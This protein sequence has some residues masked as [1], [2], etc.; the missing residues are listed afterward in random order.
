LKERLV[1]TRKGFNF[2]DSVP[3]ENQEE[4]LLK[5]YYH[6]WRTTK[7]NLNT[8]FVALYKDFKDKHLA[9][10]DGGPLRLYLYFS[11]NANNKFGHSWHS[12]ETIADFFD[13]QTRT[14]NNWIKT[15]IDKGLIY[16]EK[17]GRISHTTYLIPYSNS[18]TSQ[19]PK[20][21]YSEDGQELLEDLIS[22]IEERSFIFGEVKKVFHLFQWR[23][24]SNKP[25]IDKNG[26][27]ALLVITQRDDGVLIG[28]LCR[29]NNSSG[30]AINQLKIDELA[31][32][33]S[34]FKYKQQT[35]KG[36]ALKHNIKMLLRRNADALVELCEELNQA[37]EYD[38]LDLPAVRYGPRDEMIKEI[39][40]DESNEEDT[41]ESD[42]GGDSE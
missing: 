42:Q 39:K 10:L 1:L 29:L 23:T 7:T 40:E 14:I 15:L 6:D 35:V 4:K 25:T 19:E 32:F 36:I 34:H 3:A 26:N 22:V 37:E 30:K 16:R 41:D 11:F 24:V 2:L 13:T 28:H 33:E 31:T 12:I 18:I 5:R 17:N 38:F 8:P 27:Q 9:S 20:K 21:K